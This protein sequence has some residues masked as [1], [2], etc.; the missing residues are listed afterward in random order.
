MSIRLVLL[1]PQITI[2]ANTA[3]TCDQVDCSGHQIASSPYCFLFWQ[4]WPAISKP[5]GADNSRLTTLIGL[6]QWLLSKQR[7]L[8]GLGVKIP[9]SHGGFQICCKFIELSV[10]E[11]LLDLGMLCTGHDYWLWSIIDR[12]ADT[13]FVDVCR[14]HPQ[15]GDILI[16]MNAVR[17]DHIEWSQAGFVRA[18]C[19]WGMLQSQA[20]EIMSKS[21]EIH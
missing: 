14:C 4:Y 15:R 1:S 18:D 7:V 10:W 11:A 9:T 19:G 13:P 17:D 2:G 5:W 8:I 12:G 16:L 21:R 20:S 6:T 3:P